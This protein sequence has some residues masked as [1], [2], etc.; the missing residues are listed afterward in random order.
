MK[1]RRIEVFTATGRR[2]VVVETKRA[3]PAERPMAAARLTEPTPIP[4]QR[5][6]LERAPNGQP[7]TLERVQ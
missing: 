7:R 5:F 3:K 1:Y 6:R 4:R 2:D